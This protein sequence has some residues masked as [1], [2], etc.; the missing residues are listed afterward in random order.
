MSNGMQIRVGCK[1]D[2]LNQGNNL[3]G[4]FLVGV[5]VGGAFQNYLTLLDFCQPTLTITRPIECPQTKGRKDIDKVC[6]R[7][8]GQGKGEQR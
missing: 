1:E 4:F 2:L 8:L 7:Q 3:V 5:G 6:S